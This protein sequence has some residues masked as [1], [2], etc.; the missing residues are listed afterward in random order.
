MRVV[1]DVEVVKTLL[2]FLRSFVGFC[3]LARVLGSRFRDGIWRVGCWLE[4][5][6]GDNLWKG[7]EGCS[8]SRGRS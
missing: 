2:S 5:V 3:N 1:G 7:V 8:F 4:S 6:F